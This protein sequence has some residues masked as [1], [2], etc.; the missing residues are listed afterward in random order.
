MYKSSS[1][2]TQRFRDKGWKLTSPRNKIRTGRRCKGKNVLAL[3]KLADDVKLDQWV[4]YMRQCE[5]HGIK[6]NIP[7][8]IL[9][10]LNDRGLL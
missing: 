5:A 4:S 6:A 9:K 10:K 7:D 1:K 3:E 2:F 8:D